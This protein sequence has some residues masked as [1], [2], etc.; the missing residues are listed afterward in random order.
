M[1]TNPSDKKVLETVFRAAY[2]HGKQVVGLESVQVW[3]TGWTP[4]GAALLHL[5]GTDPALEIKVALDLEVTRG[6]VVTETGP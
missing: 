1:K 6:G 3:L 5:T 4:A 2:G